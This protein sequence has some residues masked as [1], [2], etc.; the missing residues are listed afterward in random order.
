MLIRSY[1]LLQPFTD[2]AKTKNVIY[3]ISNVLIYIASYMMLGND[4]L[5]GLVIAAICAVVTVYLIASLVLLR[6]KAPKTFKIMG[7]A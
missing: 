4:N 6:S 3:K 7:N 5:G 1:Y 2:E